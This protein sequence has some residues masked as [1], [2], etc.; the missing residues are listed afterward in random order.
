MLVKLEALGDRLRG[1]LLR[2]MSSPEAP[3]VGSTTLMCFLPSLDP[4]ELRI[5]PQNAPSFGR[6]A[7]RGVGLA[8][9]FYLD[10]S[11]R[12]LLPDSSWHT[13]G[14]NLQHC[15][16]RKATANRNQI[17]MHI[18]RSS[19]PCTG[20]GW[21]LG[22][23]TAVPDVWW[24][25]EKEGRL[26]GEAVPQLQPHAKALSPPW[27]PAHLRSIHSKD[28]FPAAPSFL[29]T[30]SPA[31]KKWESWGNACGTSVGTRQ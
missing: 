8:P 1:K 12:Q 28:A 18:T 26:E 7:L 6:A 30:S 29:P 24:D 19:S 16:A 10:F 22:P 25:L 31:A 11:L 9:G 2:E 23:G 17:F 15:T 3:G 14:N 20:H 21:S 13:V 5:P 27:I 4:H